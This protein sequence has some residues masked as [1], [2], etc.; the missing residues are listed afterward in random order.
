MASHQWERAIAGRGLRFAVADQEQLCRTGRGLEANLAIG[1][2]VAQDL[3]NP[4]S[5]IDTAI[6]MMP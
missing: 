5:C 2:A 6:S 4:L 3:A 1:V